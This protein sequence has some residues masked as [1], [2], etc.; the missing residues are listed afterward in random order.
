MNKQFVEIQA[1]NT[2]RRYTNS[3]Q[4]IA[5]G[6]ELGTG[7]VFFYDVDRLVTGSF[8][9]PEVNSD[10]LSTITQ[11]H[12]DHNEYEGEG[13]SGLELLG[14]AARMQQAQ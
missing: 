12:Y 10:N 8:I 9:D 14:H 2:G 3:G 1:W 13:L 5:A 4:R 7:R 11:R 6:I